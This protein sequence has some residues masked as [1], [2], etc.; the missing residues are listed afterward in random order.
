[1][2][3]PKIQIQN[4]LKNCDLLINPLKGNNYLYKFGVS[5][6]KWLDYMISA[7][8]ILISLNSYISIISDANCGKFIDSYNME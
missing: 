1:M 8:P 4:F 5:Q 7:K 3:R 6:N 2:T